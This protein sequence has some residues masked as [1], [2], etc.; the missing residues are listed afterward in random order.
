MNR[1]RPNVNKDLPLGELGE[2]A[3]ITEVVATLPSHRDTV[4]GPGDDAAAVSFDQPVLISTDILIEGV[5]F[6]RD[7]SSPEQIGR[8]AAAVNLADI[9][10]MGA[11]AKALVVCF[12]AP[13]ELPSGWALDCL[14][15]LSQEAAR[16]GAVIVGGDTTASRDVTIAVTV[17]GTAATGGPVTR[18]GA[19][20][21]QV[22]AMI[23][24][25]GWAA[26][27]L[28]VLQR[29]FSAP[30]DLVTAYQVPQVPYGEGA[31]AAQA[32]ASALIDISDGLLADLSH[33]AAA[34]GVCIDVDSGVFDA[35]EPLQRLSTATGA[36]PMRLILTGG[37]DHALAGCF[38][39]D[40][41]PDGWRVIGHVS[42]GRGVLVNGQDWEGD[43]GWDHFAR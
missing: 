22:V 31:I 6:R 15:G 5:H 4:I 27:G 10:A 37:E 36:D 32:G 38:D 30:R 12:S 18:R 34:S 3:L 24:R 35:P 7:W 21:G 8:K 29:G 14:S 28:V 13:P 41:V 26:G 42:E 23:G 9:E 25:V 39:S 43:L 40:C 33:I 2:F 11:R 16:C 17:L 19:C 20:P 1:N